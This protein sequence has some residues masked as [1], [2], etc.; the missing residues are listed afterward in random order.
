[1]FVDYFS[2]LDNKGYHLKTRKEEHSVDYKLYKSFRK[3][4]KSIELRDSF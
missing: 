2:I 4:F 3:C 1:M